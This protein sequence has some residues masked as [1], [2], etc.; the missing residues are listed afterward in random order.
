[1]LQIRGNEPMAGGFKSMRGQ[2]LL[3]GGNLAGSFFHRAVV[4]IC[5]HDREGAFGLVLNRKSGGKVGELIVA[6]MPEA[7]R[8]EA[9]YLGGPVQASALSYLHS[10]ADVVEGNVFSNVALGHSLETMVELT[11]ASPVGQRLRV[12]A[13][14][15]GWAPGQLEDELKRGAWVTHPASVELVFNAETDALWRSILLS[16][17]EWQFRLLANAPEDIGSN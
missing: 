2:L 14:Y 11:E 13:G 9:V 3:D 10:D 6:D 17:A 15:S 1:L 8:D 5:Q 4:L 16:R 7:L 12:F